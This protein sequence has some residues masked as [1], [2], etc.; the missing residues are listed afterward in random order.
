M[1]GGLGLAAFR[2]QIGWSILDRRIVGKEFEGDG[3]SMPVSWRCREDLHGNDRIGTGAVINHDLLSPKL[4]Q[5]L[6]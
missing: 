3:N 4:R 2:E 6:A 5:F 1:T